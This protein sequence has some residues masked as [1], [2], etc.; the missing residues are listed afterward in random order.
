MRRRGY[1][2]RAVEDPQALTGRDVGLNR[3][4]LAS[5]VTTHGMP[6]SGRLTTTGAARVRSAGHGL[7]QK[8]LKIR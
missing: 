6:G 7:R 4:I 8:A 1:F 3:T 2:V 5:S